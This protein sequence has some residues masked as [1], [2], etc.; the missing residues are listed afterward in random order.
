[1]EGHTQLV[2]GTLPYELHK[3]LLC[4][5]VYFQEEEGVIFLYFGH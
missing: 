3:D 4:F 1:M 2:E 5:I